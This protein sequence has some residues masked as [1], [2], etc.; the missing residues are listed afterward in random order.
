MF[1]PKLVLPVVGHRWRNIAYKLWEL[2]WVLHWCHIWINVGIFC[3]YV[4]VRL[5]QLV[6]YVG[7]LNDIFIYSSNYIGRF[8]CNEDRQ[9]KCRVKLRCFCATIVA[10]EKTLSITFSGCVFIALG[11]LHAMRVRHIVVCD[12][13]CAVFFH[14]ILWTAR[15]ATVSNWT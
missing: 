8:L 5:I 7:N 1:F 11:I 10:V 12:L 9:C 13:G 14:I 4:L 15:F 2:L 3:T 6:Q